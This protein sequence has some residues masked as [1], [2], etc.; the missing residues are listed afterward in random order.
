LVASGLDESIAGAAR[1]VTGRF[2]NLFD[3]EL[4]VRHEVELTPAGRF[5]LLDLDAVK[6]QEPRVLASACKALPLKAEGGQTKLMV[7]GVANTPAVVLL[8][9]RSAP[10]TVTLDG[11]PLEN[12][13]YSKEDG[14]LW[15]RFDNESRPRELSIAF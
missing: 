10:R 11:K 7:E 6:T 2:V 8:S 14:L 13:Q 9:S 15:I 4:R 5:F 1:K 3:P 12:H